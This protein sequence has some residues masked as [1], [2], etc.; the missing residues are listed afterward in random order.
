MKKGALFMLASCLFFSTMGVLVKTLSADLPSAIIVFFRNA[1]ALAGMA[2]LLHH[3]HGFPGFATRFFGQHFFRAATGLASMYCFFFSVGRLS[4]ADAYLLGYTS[5]L[6]VP[7][8]GRFFLKEPVPRW[9]WGVLAVGFG[10]LLLLLRPGAGLFTPLSAVAL[11]SGFFGAMAVTGVKQL[12]Q[13]E[14]VVRIVFYFSFISTVI[15]AFPLI[16][17]WE[18]PTLFQWGLLVASGLLATGGQLFLTKAYQYAPVAQAGPFIYSAVI[19]TGIFDVLIWGKRLDLF[20]IIGASL[21]ILAGVLAIRLMEP[22]ER[23]KNA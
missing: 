7:F 19:Y 2:L 14:P 11:G 12:V 17:V 1:V 23:G 3:R 15:S 21:I 5:P 4:L 16:A 8:M 22:D 20:W 6:F 10:G 13:E 18:T 9:L